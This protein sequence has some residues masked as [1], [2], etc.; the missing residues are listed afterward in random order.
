VHPHRAES[1]IK[2]NDLFEGDL[3]DDDRLVYVRDVIKGK[4]LESPV[5]RTQAA[6]NT[7]EQF[8]NSPDL[9]TELLNAIMSALEAHTVMSRQAL[10]SELVRTGL[11]EVLLDHV[12]LYEAL[13]GEG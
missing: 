2:L 5:L 4:L 10:N 9:K 13:R 11:R 12:G 8:A 1:I 7:R 6:N 3:T